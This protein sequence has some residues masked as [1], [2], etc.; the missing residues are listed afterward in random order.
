MHVS[1][2]VNLL[3]ANNS[4]EDIDNNNYE[5]ADTNLEIFIPDKNT[6]D[7]DIIKKSVRNQLEE[8]IREKKEKFCKFKNS[9]NASEPIATNINGEPQ[10]KY[11]DGRAVIIGDSILNDIKE[12]FSKKG[13]VV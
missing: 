4:V 7:D 12:R 11:P 5:I 9:D 8:A 1:S 3:L 6:N 13:R 2:E 10:G